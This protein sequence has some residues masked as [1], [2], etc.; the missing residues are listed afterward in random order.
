MNIFLKTIAGSI[1]TVILCVILAKQGK[2]MSVL[3][4][5]AVCCLIV[6]AAA[7]YLH[8]VVDF[9]RK[10]QAMGNIDGEIFSVLMKAV[11][12]GLLGEIVSLICADGGNAA[13]GKSVQIMTVAVMIW[14]ALPILQELLT[15]IDNILGAV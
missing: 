7:E 12:I 1:I 9:F 3:L 8:P 2:D 15:L 5:I 4:G 13:L 11:G 6:T 10:L 14:I